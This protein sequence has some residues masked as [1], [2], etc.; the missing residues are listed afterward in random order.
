MNR[1]IRSTVGELVSQLDECLFLSADEFFGD[2]LLP[3]EVEV[4]AALRDPGLTKQS[5]SSFA[6]SQ[7]RGRRPFNGR[8]I[9]TCKSR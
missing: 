4:E 3:R 8:R 1:V 2:L 9:D 6:W 5:A 7:R